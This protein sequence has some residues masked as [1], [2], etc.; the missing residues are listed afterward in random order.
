MASNRPNVRF[1]GRL[2]PDRLPDLYR[3]ALAVVI[4]SLCYEV[5]PMVVLEAFREATPVIVR[6]LGPFPEIIDRSRAGL[7]F[8][9]S[10][11]LKRTLSMIV[12]KR[13]LRDGLGQAGR[14][15]FESYWSEA[16][17]LKRYFELIRDLALARGRESITQIGK[18]P[19]LAVRRAEVRPL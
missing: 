2:H 11:D 19:P 18:P 13:G 7:P 5:F 9:D 8:D 12:E 14:K 1:L 10:A 6:R 16:E 4:P 3:K 15:A 17:A